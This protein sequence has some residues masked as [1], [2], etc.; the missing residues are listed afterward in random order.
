LLDAGVLGVD[1]A[2][3][4]TPTLEALASGTVGVGSG[5]LAATAGAVADTI[6]EAIGATSPVRRSH[7]RKATTITNPEETRFPIMFALRR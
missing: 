1:A 6:S 4:S 7:P 2:T 3:A 5:A